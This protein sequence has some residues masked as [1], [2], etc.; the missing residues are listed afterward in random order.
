MDQ[1]S[2]TVFH[3]REVEQDIL[4]IFLNGNHTKYFRIYFICLLT[5]ISQLSLF[6]DT[7]LFTSHAHTHTHTHAHTHTHT[8]T[9]HPK[10]YQNHESSFKFVKKVEKHIKFQRYA[11]IISKYSTYFLIPAFSPAKGIVFL[12]NQ[13]LA[14]KRIQRLI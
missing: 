8:H 13:Q 5:S 9:H 7:I 12:K 1:E 2:P 10:I 11:Y 3:H 4:C 14:V 6:I